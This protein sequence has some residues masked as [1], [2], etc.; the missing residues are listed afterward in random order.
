MIEK[1]YEAM[2]MVRDDGGRVYLVD[3]DKAF[4]WYIQQR[5]PDHDTNGALGLEVLLKLSEMADLHAVWKEAW[6]GFHKVLAGALAQKK[7][8]YV[9]AA[10]WRIGRAHMGLEDSELAVLFLEA[11][12]RLTA[13]DQNTVLWNDILL[14]LGVWC[15]MTRADLHRFDATLAKLAH[16]GS[17]ACGIDL[18]ELGS[19]A[20]RIQAQA[21]RNSKWKD[22]AGQWIPSAMRLSLAQSEVSLELNRKCG[23]QVPVG[24]VL[25][26]MA[27]IQKRLGATQQ[28]RELYL[29][30]ISVLSECGQYGAVHAIRERLAAI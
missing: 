23:R 18:P 21:N 28:A 8:T 24:F 27:D 22:E 15:M 5:F 9:P 29:Q 7:E 13:P 25:C 26:N 4:Q 30:S 17:T 16:R 1:L 19:L 20:D 3:R 11:A 12:L 10:V 14:D 2:R 6:A